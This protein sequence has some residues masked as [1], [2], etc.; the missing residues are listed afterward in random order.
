[1]GEQL[2]TGQF[3]NA[4]P[5]LERVGSHE[6]TV[7]RNGQKTEGVLKQQVSLSF[8]PY[9]ERTLSVSGMV[10]I[11]SCFH[12]VTFIGTTPPFPAA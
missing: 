2:Q 5:S 4:N 9:E 1:M 7:T 10:T 11:F 6:V 8:D 12:V 3:P